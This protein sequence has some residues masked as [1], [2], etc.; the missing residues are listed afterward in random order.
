MPSAVIPGDPGQGWNIP[1][2]LKG[3]RL[4]NA[5]KNKIAINVLYTFKTDVGNFTPSVSYIWRDKA[6][7]LFFTENYWAAPKW[8]EWDARLSWKSANNRFEAIAFIKNIANTW[9]FDQGPIATRAAGT[10]DIFMAGP[11]AGSGTYQPVNYVQGVNGPAGFNNKLLGAN[12]QGIYQTLYP[13]PP[14]TFG[15]ELHYKFF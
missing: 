12:S 9:G 11:V 1:Q 14:R 8:D 7:G 4:P 10:S 3:Y 2:N 15:I 5:P 13:T 6:Y